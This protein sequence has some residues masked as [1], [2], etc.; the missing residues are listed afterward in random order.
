MRS[1]NSCPDHIHVRE[2]HW[3]SFS[4]RIS[5]DIIYW[6]D[7]KLHSAFNICH[8]TNNLS[9][10]VSKL[11]TNWCLG[12]RKQLRRCGIDWVW[13]SDAIYRRV[14]YIY[15]YRWVINRDAGYLRRYRAHHDATV[16]ITDPVNGLELQIGLW[17][18]ADFLSIIHRETNLSEIVIKSRCNDFHLKKCI[19][20]CCLQHDGHVCSCSH[21]FTYTADKRL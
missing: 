21:V 4:S 19:W 13:P 18:N 12:V 9:Q 1:S 11:P 5:Y 6:A 15:R 20:K 2:R 17:I 14:T 16:M 3:N 10:Y 8:G 7:F